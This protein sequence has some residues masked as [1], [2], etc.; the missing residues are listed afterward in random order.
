MNRT[1][2]IKQAKG[3]VRSKGLKTQITSDPIHKM[4]FTNPGK[5]GGNRIRRWDNTGE[6]ST[7]SGVAEDRDE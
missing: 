3:H 4:G 7:E 5:D 1:K 2:H 6:L